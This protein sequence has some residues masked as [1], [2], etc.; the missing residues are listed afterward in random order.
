MSCQSKMKSSEYLME[1]Q[2]VKFCNH[3]EPL[4][5]LVT[6][7]ATPWDN[8]IHTLQSV[9]LSSLGFTFYKDSRIQDFIRHIHNYTEYNQ[10]WNVIQVR[11]M[12]NAIICNTNKRIYINISMKKMK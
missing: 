10:Q 2:K 5:N 8:L 12:Y 9:P 1:L 6:H 11:S 4:L 7:Q 3:T